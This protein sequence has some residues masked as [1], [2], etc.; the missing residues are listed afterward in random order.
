MMQSG[1]VSDVGYRYSLPRPHEFR[2]PGPLSPPNAAFL[3]GLTWT[4]AAQ[5]HSAA[6][7][8]TTHFRHREKEGGIAGEGR[9]DEGR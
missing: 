8:G 3:L 9:P 6:F 4:A 2:S 7:Q 5:S 1:R